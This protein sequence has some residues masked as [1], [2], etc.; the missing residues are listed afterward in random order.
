MPESELLVQKPR[1]NLFTTTLGLQVTSTIPTLGPQGNLQP[2]LSS[3]WNQSASGQ[4][5]PA[6]PRAQ[7]SEGSSGTGMAVPRLNDVPRASLGVVLA[8]ASTPQRNSIQGRVWYLPGH[9][10]GSSR[11]GGG[12]VF[13]SVS[14]LVLLRVVTRVDVLTLLLIPST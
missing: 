5:A 10:G 3:S 11:V 4:A 13:S 9:I 2:R 1:T 6:A 14:L 7:S 8:C 12:L